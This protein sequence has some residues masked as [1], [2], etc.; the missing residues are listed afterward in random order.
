MDAISREGYVNKLKNK[1]FGC[2]C[3]REKNGEWEAYLDSILIE[4]QGIDNKSIDFYTI[5]Y[6]LSSCRY[7]SYK[8]FRKTIFDVMNIIDSMFADRRD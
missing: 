6:K 8:Y 1:L 4:L 3:E 2:L 7:L 5:Y